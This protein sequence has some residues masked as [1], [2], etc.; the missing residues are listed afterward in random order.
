M[1]VDVLRCDPVQCVSL[2]PEIGAPGR[3]TRHKAHVPALLRKHHFN[4]WVPRRASANLVQHGSR[5][6][7][8][9]PGADEER[10]DGNRTEELQRAALSVIVGRVASS[11]ARSV[12]ALVSRAPSNSPG[13]RSRRAAAFALRLRRK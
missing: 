11:K 6:E 9:V 13:N 4:V 2:E 8:V 1:I 10:R 5:Q 12:R 7:R 3:G